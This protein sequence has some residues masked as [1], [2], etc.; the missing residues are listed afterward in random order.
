MPTTAPK[1]PSWEFTEGMPIA[2]GRNVVK[3]LGGGSRYEV[4]LVWDGRLFALAVA[5]IL[6]PGQT[7]DEDARANLRSEAEVLRR[8]AHPVI[9]RAF[10]AV[11]DG[12]C[13]HLL[14]E[15]VEGPS[16][17]SLLRRSG[18][19][20][21]EQLLPLAL[22][23]AAAIHYLAGEGMVHLDIK[24]D[25]IIMGSPPRLIDLS[26]VHEIDAARRLTA[27]IGTDAYMA[28]EQCGQPGHGEIGPATDVFGLAATMQHALT[29]EVPFPRLDNARHSAE[30]RIRWPQL[31]EP[32][33]PLP[34][35]IPPE[36]T[37]LLRAALRPDPAERPVAA[38][39]ATAL[40]PLV[41]AI[42]TRRMQFRRRPGPLGRRAR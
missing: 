4:Y 20:S 38:E 27:H 35:G 16:L 37:R 12:P 18:P 30:P 14:I 19:L 21:L 11:Y 41:S 24:P 17:Q 39:F 7:A 36:L 15:Y 25:N 9:I 1:H 6:R 26:L 3:L 8:L 5:K 40:E 42:A 31:A 28:P 13:P 33:L 2:D 34:S 22:H 10:D 23:V 29:G 32:P